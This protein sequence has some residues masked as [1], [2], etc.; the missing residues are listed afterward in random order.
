MSELDCADSLLAALGSDGAQ[1]LVVNG[2]VTLRTNDG[3]TLR[4]FTG[5]LC[6]TSVRVVRVLH[7]LALLLRFACVRAGARVTRGCMSCFAQM[8]LNII[9]GPGQALEAHR[10]TAFRSMD[11]LLHIENVSGARVGMALLPL[12]PEYHPSSSPTTPSR[13]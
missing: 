11:R 10:A 1:Q 9:E 3:T 5:E 4:K 2:E 12:I 7:L 8:L 13:S 6:L